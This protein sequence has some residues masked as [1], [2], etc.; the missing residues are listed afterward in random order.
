MITKHVVSNQKGMSLVGI[1]VI[2]SASMI[3]ILGLLSLINHLSKAQAR[4]QEKIDA[5]ELRD[6]LNAL[7]WDPAVCSAVFAEQV[8]D[9]KPE[10]I[11]AK[12]FQRNSEIK[13]KKIGS[14]NFIDYQLGNAKLKDLPLQFIGSLGSDFLA[15][16]Y[17]EL[18]SKF[19]NKSSSLLL[20]VTVTDDKIVSCTSNIQQGSGGGSGDEGDWD[21][22]TDP[23]SLV[24]RA[25]C[26]YET[27]N[28]AIDAKVEKH[29]PSG[30]GY[31]S[32]FYVGK[33]YGK[34]KTPDD[35]LPSGYN[36][37]C[38]SGNASSP[39]ETRSGVGV[40]QWNC[41]LSDGKSQEETFSPYFSV[42][43]EIDKS[44]KDD[45]LRAAIASTPGHA[46]DSLLKKITCSKVLE[47]P[48]P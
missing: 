13:S 43:A 42:C 16:T 15:R 29:Q 48:Q 21:S 39:W 35:G 45:V 8:V 41:V 14:H 11:E 5:M 12:S 47:A 19:N 6:E 17:I 2:L 24:S 31:G 4:I 37:E 32:S 23:S 30:G 10:T 22:G 25:G 40:Q 18:D 3:I 34:W 38:N 20:R 44:G 33:L 46:C 9:V 7:F 1:I 27:S 28:F 36:F 26:S